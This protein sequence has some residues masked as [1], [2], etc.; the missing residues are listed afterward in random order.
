M[1]PDIVSVNDAGSVFYSSNRLQ[2]LPIRKIDCINLTKPPAANC[3]TTLLRSTAR[4][5]AYYSSSVALFPTYRFSNKN[6]HF[7]L[8]SIFYRNITNIFHDI[9]ST[10]LQQNKCL[11]TY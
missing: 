7:P 8:F 11:S 9:F 5:A 4:A 3:T 10:S 1:L 2:T 6:N